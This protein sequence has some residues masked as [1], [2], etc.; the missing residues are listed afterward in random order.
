MKDFSDVF[1]AVISGTITAK[2]AAKKIAKNPKFWP[3][4]ATQ[5]FKY[6]YTNYPE[7]RETLAKIW[8]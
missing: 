1:L 3:S 4:Q 8:V 6:L 5:E 7:H 2:S